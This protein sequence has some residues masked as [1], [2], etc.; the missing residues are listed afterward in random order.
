VRRSACGGRT[1]SRT[2]GSCSCARRCCRSA[3]KVVAGVP[4][5]RAGE[6]E[7]SLDVESAELVAAQRALQAVE[8]DVLGDAYA[9]MDLVFAWED[10]TTLRPDYV[11]RRFKMLGVAAGLPEITLH[12]GRHT[13]ATLGLEAGLD[14]KIVSDQL[15]HSNVN[16]TRNRYQHVRRT[17]HATA[18]EAIVALLPPRPRND[19]PGRQTPRGQAA[20]KPGHAATNE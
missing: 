10:G 1:W 4:K 20:A 2:T 19:G 15:G 9:D 13:A 14:V 8:R 18:A 17:I 12:M 5:T 3:A 6:R 16:F 7:V 11:S